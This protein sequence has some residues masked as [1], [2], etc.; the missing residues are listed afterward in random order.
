VL[1]QYE[2]KVFGETN[3]VQADIKRLKSYFGGFYEKVQQRWSKKTNVHRKKMEDEGYIL[4]GELSDEIIQEAADTI[5]E[6]ETSEELQ[7]LIKKEIKKLKVSETE[8][9]EALE[10]VK[11]KLLD[12]SSSD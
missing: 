1:D 2:K 12:E 7:A 8:V 4:D 11:K 9:L 3:S 6:L 10:E 5:T